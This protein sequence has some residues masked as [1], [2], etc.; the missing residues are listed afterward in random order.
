VEYV[1]QADTKP[2]DIVEQI[3]WEANR[4]FVVHHDTKIIG[5]GWYERLYG[6]LAFCRILAVATHCQ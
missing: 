1:R 6:G 4:C 5:W 3:R 2:S